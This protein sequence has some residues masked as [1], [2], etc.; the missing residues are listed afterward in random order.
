M[1]KEEIMK[2]Q[3]TEIFQD[4][5]IIPIYQRKYSWTYKEIEQ[6]LEDIINNENDKYFL[7]TLTVDKKEDG[8]YEVID[9][10]QRLTT[11][12]LIMIYLKKDINNMLSFEA[13]QIYDN[14][15]NTLKSMKENEEIGAYEDNVKEIYEGYRWIENY[16]KNNDSNSDKFLNKLDNTFL[17]RVQVPEDTD[18]NHYFEI[19]NT[20]GEQLELHHIAKAKFLNVINNDDRKTASIIWDAC[21]QMNR[22]VQMTFKSDIR[23]ELFKED[24]SDF[25]EDVSNWDTLK[26]I[27]NNTAD[28]E[29][30][31][32]L[33]VIIKDIKDGKFDKKAYENDNNKDEKPE[34]FESIITFPYFLLHLNA[35]QDNNSDENNLYDDKKL[36][37][38][39]KKHY[40]NEESA[41][42]FIFSML[43]CRFLFDKYIVKRDY[44]DDDNNLELSLLT[45]THNN[46]NTYLVNT[47]GGES[48]K[49]IQDTL[50]ALQ[51]LLRITY[52]S[53]RNMKWITALLKHLFDG[54]D[55]GLV[56][57]TSVLENHCIEKIKEH[58]NINGIA[59]IEDFNEKRYNDIERIVFTYLDYLL[60]RDGY[61]DIIKAGFNWKV[62]FRNSV[63]HFFPQNPE[64]NDEW[65]N[66]DLHCFGNLALVTVSGNSKFSNLYP[67]AK[68]K[69]Y[70]DKD[71]IEQNPK[72]KIM[73][74]YTKDGGEWTPEKAEEHQKEMFEILAKEINSKK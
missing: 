74:S 29:D 50:K 5:Y 19:M 70:K 69:Q 16:F 45:Y 21:S 48:G 36:L 42:K 30:I 53:P 73:A 71:M 38:N 54:K 68:I 33:E 13:R 25:K 4:K 31:K 58:Y 52:T 11:L 41:K 47:Y 49:S 37:E 20:R 23:K 22:Y 56:S 57:V 2:I 26:N 15:L 24:L 17:V 18:L 43:K 39:L 7:G 63:E 65:S 1:N 44:Q 61:K 62:Q 12:C 55:A 67:E 8:R 59:K 34:R 64:N 35:L 72:L 14:A 3:I 46:G 6:L 9:G 27:F 32:K 51:S 66:D 28:N 60:Y 40:E 10:Q